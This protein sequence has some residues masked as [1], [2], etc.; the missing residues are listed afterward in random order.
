VKIAHLQETPVVVLDIPE[1]VIGVYHYS[2]I[3]L[4]FYFVNSFVLL[5]PREASTGGGTSK[6]V[7]ACVVSICDVRKPK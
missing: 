3:K 6:V 5:A 7:A 2:Q 1:V 4:L